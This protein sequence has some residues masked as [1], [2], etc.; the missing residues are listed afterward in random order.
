MT[1]LTANRLSVSLLTAILHAL[2]NTPKCIQSSEI[3]PTSWAEMFLNECP[4]DTLPIDKAS[5]LENDNRIECFH[6][7]AA[8]DPSN[9]T[10]RPEIDD[11]I[12]IHFA[13][14]ACVNDKL[15]DL[16]GRLDGPICHGSTSIA[17]FLKD[18]CGVV[19]KWM[20]ADK[21]EMRFTMLALAPSA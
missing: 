17:N 18:A 19:Q 21:N 4:A 5:I 6:D 11:K 12:G 10:N 3:E 20:D 1:S 15:C 7:A 9:Q 13:T 2:F 14:F 8:K 16:D